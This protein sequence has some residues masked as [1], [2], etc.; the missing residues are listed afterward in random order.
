MCR[1]VVICDFTVLASSNRNTQVS[2]SEHLQLPSISISNNSEILVEVRNHL[3]SAKKAYFGF[4]NV[5]VENPM[6]EN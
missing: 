1:W 6:K 5:W 2:D 4:T 3:A